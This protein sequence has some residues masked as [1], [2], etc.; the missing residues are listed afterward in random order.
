[1]SVCLH[2]RMCVLS[3]QTL[4]LP[5]SFLYLGFHKS[6]I[7]LSVGGLPWWLRA[8]ESACSADVGSVPGLERSPGGR[9][10]NPLQYPCGK[11]PRTEEPVSLYS[12]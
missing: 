3:R 1:M 7:P 6:H 5:K 2:V 10:V 12:P 11:I 4:L 8:K 9:N